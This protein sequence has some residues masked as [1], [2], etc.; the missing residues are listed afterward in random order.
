MK[1]ENNVERFYN[2][3]TQQIMRF[4]P[5]FTSPHGE[6]IMGVSLDSDIETDYD[7]ELE[8]EIKRGQMVMVSSPNS[9]DRGNRIKMSYKGKDL[10]TYVR[11]LKSFDI[12]DWIYGDSW[13]NYGVE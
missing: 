4:Q 9:I 8:Y 13:K 7:N 3:T 11:T 5:L 2:K 1:N 12:S 10:F 6:M